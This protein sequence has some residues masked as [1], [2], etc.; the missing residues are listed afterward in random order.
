MSS[1]SLVN[2]RENLPRP[3]PT[4]GQRRA[5]PFNRFVTIGSILIVAIAFGDVIAISMQRDASIAAYE[6]ATTNLSRGMSA[7]TSHLLNTLDK[8]LAEVAARIATSSSPEMGSQSASALLAERG[9]AMAEFGSF[10]VVD[11]SGRVVASTAGVADP[12]MN[13]F[14]ESMRAREAQAVQVEAGD[15]SFTLSRRLTDRSGGFAGVVTATVSAAALRDFYKIAMPPRRTVTLMSEGG[16]I[17]A[18]YPLLDTSAIANAAHPDR[19]A[20]DKGACAAYFGPDVLND[21]PVV[22]T[23]C[24]FRDLPFTLETSAPAAEALALW[25]Q[26]RLWLAIGGVF[27]SLVVVWLLYVF[28]R[29]MRRLE[30]SELSLAAEKR[31]A[32]TAH[33]QL[34]IALSNIIQG[35][36]FFDSDRN[37]MVVNRRFQELYD[38]PDDSVRPGARLSD[39][40]DA[41]SRHVGLRDFDRD[42]YLASLE[43]IA[44]ARAPSASVLELGNG[45]TLAIQGQALANGG[46]VATHEDITERRRAEDKISH[47]AKH[48]ALTGLVNRSVLTERLGQLVDATI[49]EGRFAVLFVDLDCFK[50]VNDT[51]GHDVGDALLQQV[52]G[53]LK[54]TAPA[55]ATIA[56]FGG[57][58]FVI[59]LT[60]VTEADEVARLARRLIEVVSAPYRINP[61]E[62]VIGASIGIEL[63]KD[64]TVSAD[65]LL[66]NADIALYTSKS[67]GRGVYRFFEPDADSR[68]R[69]RL[70]VETELRNALADRHFKIA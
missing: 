41:I 25:R 3:D 70:R 21:A 26:E 15:D 39:I 60:G 11:A 65:T 5:W 66:K 4:R 56:R 49:R 44:R 69:D 61:H 7:Q 23:I 32:E 19:L 53:R 46:W 36:C 24:R 58:E 10:A 33:Q 55:H 12:P 54:A 17:L 42:G 28:A 9:K 6:T 22:A 13:R 50:A 45:R 37:L 2:A 52:A 64:E 30:I 16:A 34:D 29:Q 43:Q 18:Q 35:V 59:L 31:Q 1:S 63:S 27:A 8:L 67:Q 68:L 38:L 57:D 62:V 40:V 47:L 48:D 20:V 51:L 14:L